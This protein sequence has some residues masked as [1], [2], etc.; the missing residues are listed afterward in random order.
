[1]TVSELKHKL[2]LQIDTLDEHQLEEVYGVLINYLNEQKDISDW[3]KLSDIQKKGI[4]YAVKELE[5]GKGI[6][7]DVVFN[8]YRTK[9]AHG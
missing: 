6:P 4:S 5:E 2:F 1:M 9:Y 7:N 8:K 3:D